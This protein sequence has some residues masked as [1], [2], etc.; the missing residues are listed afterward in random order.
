MSNVHYFLFLI[1]YLLSILL[2]IM[3]SRHFIFLLSIFSIVILSLTPVVVYA[4][5]ELAYRGRIYPG[6]QIDKSKIKNQKSKILKLVNGEK[7]WIVQAEQLGVNL[8]WDRTREKL[9][10]TG[11]N[12][13]FGKDLEIKYRAY[14][15]GITVEPEFDYNREM[16]AE[17]VAS[18][19]GEIDR[20]VVEP[21]FR[22]T[23][24]KVTE[25]VRA[26]SAYDGTG[27][28]LKPEQPA[29]GGVALQRFTGFRSGAEGFPVKFI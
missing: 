21:K 27:T 17:L 29:R 5:Y 14:R 3:L 12:G 1:H 23:Q 24:G 10:R 8:D 22:L 18:V 4:T 20:P 11:R 9:Y 7:E 13:D 2:I 19:S 6:V 15:Q 28:V 16:A 25:F 26:E